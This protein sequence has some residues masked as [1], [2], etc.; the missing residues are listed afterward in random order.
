LAEN[1]ARDTANST[2]SQEIPM[3]AEII[4]GKAIAATIRAEITIEVDEL[5]AKTGR[6]PGLATVLV[7]Q[8]KDSQSYVRMK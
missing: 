2:Q 1:N 6:V 4:D 7:G 8:R 3:P 5:K